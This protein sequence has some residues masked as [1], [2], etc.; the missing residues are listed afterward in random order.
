MIREHSHLIQCIRQARETPVHTISRSLLDRSFVL[1]LAIYHLS[2]YLS[3]CMFPV[4]GKGGYVEEVKRY[5][6]GLSDIHCNCEKLAI[7]AHVQCRYVQNRGSLVRTLDPIFVIPGRVP[8]AFA[9]KFFNC[10][11][12]SKAMY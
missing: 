5:F 6:Q 7:C 12:L 8:V 11:E 10:L 4:L 2:I 9:Y 1:G 3:I